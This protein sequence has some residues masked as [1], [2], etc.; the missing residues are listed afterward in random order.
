MSR[1]TPSGRRSSGVIPANVAT[2][3]AHAS[4]AS[5]AGYT[6]SRASLRD[7]PGMVSAASFAR[8][9]G[10]GLS[11]ETIARAPC[12]ADRA[13]RR[14]PARGL[15]RGSTRASRRPA[16]PA[17]WPCAARAWRSKGRGRGTAPRGGSSPPA[18]RTGRS[19]GRGAI[20]SHP[21]PCRRGDRARGR[22]AAWRVPGPR[23]CA[24][25]R[26]RPTAPGRLD[27]SRSQRTRSP[28]S[29]C[30][31]RSSG[32]QV[33]GATSFR[34]EVT[35]FMAHAASSRRRLGG[36]ARGRSQIVSPISSRKSANERLAWG[37]RKG[38]GMDMKAMTLVLSPG[39]PQ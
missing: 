19:G 13:P 16:P 28:F 12:R 2:M 27:Q 38:S 15:P 11:P 9:S 30:S 29:G 8:P 35:S 22:C 33:G 4:G 6:A 39:K 23:D 5:T 21:S 10:E 18:R 17:G 3:W 26:H 25:P 7:T 32:G 36:A 24:D 1:S 37:A 14:M 20:R 31:G 34:K